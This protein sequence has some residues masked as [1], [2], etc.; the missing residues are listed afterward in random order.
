VASS[1]VAM[2]PVAASA[3]RHSAYLSAFPFRKLGPAMR[4][5][6]V[7]LTRD[8]SKRQRIIAQIDLDRHSHGVAIA[9][10]DVW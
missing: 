2:S 1:N 10:G 5:F 8:G 9:R 7:A 4:S 3:N 6:I